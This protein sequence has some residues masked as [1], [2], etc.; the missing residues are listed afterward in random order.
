MPDKTP[1]GQNHVERRSLIGQ[2]GAA[3][4]AVLAA[5]AAATGAM[6]ADSAPA[7]AQRDGDID[8]VK[9]LQHGGAPSTSP[10]TSST[11]K[12]SITSAASWA[13]AWTPRT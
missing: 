1:A 6:V 2:F 4:V 12:A 3:A 7:A 13:A 9:P 11:W 10:S 5:G 8:R